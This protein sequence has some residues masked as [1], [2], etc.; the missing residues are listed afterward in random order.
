MIILRHD[1]PL[2][3]ERNSIHIRKISITK[4]RLKNCIIYYIFKHKVMSEKVIKIK[5]GLDINM[6]GGAERVLVK[7]AIPK[8]YGLC[9]DE[10]IG[11]T[12]KLLVQQGEAV[13]VGTPLFFSKAQP[14]VLFTSPTAGVVKEVVRGEKRKILAIEIEASEEQE[15][16]NF[17]PLSA[18]ASTQEVKELLLQS[19][20]WP[21]IIQRPFGIIAN[22]TQ[23]PRD[24]FISAFDSAPLAADKSFLLQDEAD[25]LNAGIA[26]LSKLTTGGV[27][28]GVSSDRV[29]SA[30]SKIEGATVHTFEGSHPAGNVGV[31]IERVAPMAKSDLVWT[32]DIVHVAMIGRLARTGVV[33]FSRTIAVAGSCVKKPMYFK[34]TQG[35]SVGVL[36]ADNIDVSKSKTGSIRVINGDVLSGRRVSENGYLGYYN[37]VLTVIPEGDYYEFMGWASPR[38]KKFSTSRS[39]FSWL[40]PKKKYNIDTNLNGGRRAFVVNGVYEAVLPMDIYPVYLLKAIMAEDIDKMEQLGI[41]EVIEED[42]A[43]CEFVCPSKIEWQQTLRD[44]I[45]KMIK[46]L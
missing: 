30:I 7:A 40:T 21:M 32:V 28:L 36:L 45:T 6:V 18:S 17:T 23:T 46:E 11:V 27:H 26:L 31:H 14:E 19:G 44:G 34:T 13:R 2:N 16:V 43:L 20:Y 37:N 41:Y 22:P 1:L 15:A 25:N 3:Q 24:I 10:F 39:Y 4:L 8:T 29:V 38:L 35:A 42:L 5:R 33:D 12:P 9:P